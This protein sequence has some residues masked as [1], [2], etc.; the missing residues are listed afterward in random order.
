MDGKIVRGD[1][2]RVFSRFSS[3][4]K[5]VSLML[6]CM[7]SPYSYFFVFPTARPGVRARRC[8]DCPSG[9]C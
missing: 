8:C 3:A 5:S 6:T 7:A 2:E 4:L 1:V 9:F